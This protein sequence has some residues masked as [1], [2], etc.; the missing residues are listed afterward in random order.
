MAEI[1]NIEW[2]QRL[3]GE[4][5]NI[6][7]DSMVWVSVAALDAAWRGCE[8]YIGPGGGRIAPRWSI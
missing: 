4:G 3:I 1:L 7:P 5:W 2:R 8:G 6:E